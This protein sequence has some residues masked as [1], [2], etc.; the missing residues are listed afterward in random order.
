MENILMNFVEEKESKIIIKE[1][2]IDDI[3]RYLTS[4]NESKEVFVITNPLVKHLHGEKLISGFSRYGIHS[5]FIEIPDGEKYKSLSTASDIYDTLLKEKANRSTTLI[6]FGGGVIGD[7]TGFIA[8]TYMRGVPLIHIP[9][10]LLSQ[11]DSSIGGKVAVDHPKAKNI[12][13]S[14]YHPRAIF[15][16]PLVLGTLPLEHIKNG[17]VEIIKISVIDSPSLFATLDGVIQRVLNKDMEILKTII[18]DAV[19]LKV[20]VVL[21]DPKENNQRKYLNFGHSIGHALE[22]NFGYQKLTHGEAVALGMVIETKISRY[23]GICSVDLEKKIKSII[24]KLNISFKITFKNM[25][26]ENIWETIAFDK[27]NK[28]G[29]ICFILP[30]KIGK[31]NLIEGI[32]KKEVINALEEFKKEWL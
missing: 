5:K 13:G 30:E 12:I 1:G 7:L 18:S 31:V 11:V 20:H 4:L 16:D 25:H 6:S 32:N 14:F 2:L 8:S 17:L 19:K 28:Q 22:T 3:G 21:Q 27:K 26:N 24:N 29:R 9:T 10:T 15:I 23:R